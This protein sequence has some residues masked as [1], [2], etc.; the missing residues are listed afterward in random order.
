[1]PGPLLALGISAGAALGGEIAGRFV[2][3]EEP[4]DYYLSNF[5]QIANAKVPG[6]LLADEI[7]AITYAGSRSTGVSEVNAAA[8][9]MRGLRKPSSHAHYD[10][11]MRDKRVSETVLKVNSD[12]K[13][14]A[15]ERKFKLNT[16]TANAGAKNIKGAQMHKNKLA[17]ALAARSIYNYEQQVAKR[18]AV[19]SAVG[20]GLGVAAA[21][22]MD[23]GARGWFGQ[24]FSSEPY[25][26]GGP[27][28]G[29]AGS[30]PMVEENLLD[31]LPIDSGL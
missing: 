6:Y 10:A 18:E 25:V 30:S 29:Y 23:P 20:S 31:E 5:W 1:M 13:R 26:S 27:G 15:A 24:M 21:L 4:I 2:K 8:A 17:D 19:K 28:G 11:M 16:L 3:T 9:A 12:L 7:R 22:A 14:K